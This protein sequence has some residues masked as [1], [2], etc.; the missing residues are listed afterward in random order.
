[1]GPMQVEITQVKEGIRFGI[2]KM[3]YHLRPRSCWA[4]WVQWA[5][6]PGNHEWED[7]WNRR[8]TLCGYCGRE[9]L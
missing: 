5:L 1:M 7:V 8:C 9:E 6:F 3:A 4:M 2:A